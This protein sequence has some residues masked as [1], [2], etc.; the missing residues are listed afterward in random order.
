M[1]T[2]KL[3]AVKDDWQKIVAQ[4]WRI[5]CSKTLLSLL[6]FTLNHVKLGAKKLIPFSDSPTRQRT[7]GKNEGKA[8]QLSHVEEAELM[9]ALTEIRERN[10]T[11]PA[12]NSFRGLFR[13]KLCPERILLNELDV[14][15]H[16]ESSVRK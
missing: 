7:R 13:C 12:D 14:Q 11:D 3:F 5:S 9:D 8:P 4:L 16:L 6:I 15:K 10:N 1:I 2:K